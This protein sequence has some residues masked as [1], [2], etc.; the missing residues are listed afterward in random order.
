MSSTS[1]PTFVLIPG[2]SSNAL[3]FGPLSNELALLGHRSYAVDLPGHGLAAGQPAAYHRA[4]ADGSALASAPSALAGLTLAD[5]VRHVAG[6]VRR[7][8]AHGP[9]TVV[10]N[11]FGGLTL[12]A[13]GNAVPE[14]VDRLVY[15]SALVFADVPTLL[16]EVDLP[17]RADNLLDPA[18]TKIAVGNPVEQGYARLNWRAA[19]SDPTLFAELKAAIMGEA[20]DRLFRS[21][22]DTLDVDENLNPLEP[23]A[24]IDPATWGRVPHTF[25]RLSRDRCVPLAFQNR[26][27]ADADAATPDNPFDVH[28]LP[29]SHVGYVSRPRE[30]A[31]LLAGLV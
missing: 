4:P 17:E 25:V 15:L 8:A 26:M 18:T 2:G 16:G 24:V 21:F 19:H 9:V 29:L 10:A 30:V 22:L 6:V 13:L 20:D 11:S 28:T 1:S 3:A 27:I 14:L 7:L 23:G 31:E 12:S 5:N